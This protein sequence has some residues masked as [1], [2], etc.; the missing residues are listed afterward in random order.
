MT[1]EFKSTQGVLVAR[2]L[3][4][5]IDAQA[6]PDLKAQ[7]GARMDAGEGRV[8]IDL[9]EVDLVDSTGLGALL[10]LYKK[11]PRRN[12][13]F[14]LC[15]CRSTV[16]DLMRITRMERVFKFLPGEAEAVASLAPAAPA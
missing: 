2:I 1:I 11:A 3:E 10:F 16:L 12:G 9:G 13:G 14:V 6:A 15:S 5:R 7:V 4:R 8:V